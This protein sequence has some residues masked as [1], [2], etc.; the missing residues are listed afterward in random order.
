MKR[1]SST[2]GSGA[3]LGAG[4]GGGGR[5]LMAAVLTPFVM[6]VTPNAMKAI[7]DN[8]HVNKV[9]KS[10]LKRFLDNAIKI[11]ANQK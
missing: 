2:V 5:S 1:E 6:V 11:F 9:Q 8:S 10:V 7:T 3:G 4:E